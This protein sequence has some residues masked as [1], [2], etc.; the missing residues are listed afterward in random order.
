MKYNLTYPPRSG[1]GSINIEHVLG[2]DIFI[3]IRNVNLHSLETSEPPSTVWTCGRHSMLRTSSC[4]SSS[5]REAPWLFT[6][7]GCFSFPD[8][9]RS[10]LQPLACQ[11]C[12]HFKVPITIQSGLGGRH[13]LAPW[14]PGGN[15]EEPRN[16]S[17][18]LRTS[19]NTG[20]SPLP[21][22]FPL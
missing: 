20:S 14:Q 13:Y 9:C 22:L 2:I 1:S 6:R 18:C 15:Y 12:L 17:P 10:K 7:T 21:H 19:A 3:S 8:R 11:L 5:E 16:S 4:P